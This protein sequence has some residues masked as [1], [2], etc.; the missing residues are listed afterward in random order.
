MGLVPKLLTCG[1]CQCV[2]AASSSGGVAYLW[3]P[4]RFCPIWWVAS[5]S[6]LSGVISSLETGEFI[7]FSHIYAPTDL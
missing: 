7:L 3:N 4:L 5:R 1:E 2:G 6:S